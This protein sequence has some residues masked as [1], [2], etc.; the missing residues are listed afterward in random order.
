MQKTGG[1]SSRRCLDIFFW[2]SNEQ[3]AKPAQVCLPVSVFSWFPYLAWIQYSILERQDYSGIASYLSCTLK[4]YFLPG[5]KRWDV[6]YFTIQ[7]GSI[8]PH[9][10]IWIFYLQEKLNLMVPDLTNTY[11]ANNVYS[12]IPLQI[13]ISSVFVLQFIHIKFFF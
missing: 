7:I 4:L 12:T 6:L 5:S 9:L 11:I 13:F 8:N 2:E 10:G 3:K 1:I